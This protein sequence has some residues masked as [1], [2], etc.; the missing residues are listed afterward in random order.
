MAQC[1]AARRV[2]QLREGILRNRR[3]EQVGERT[4]DD[5]A[6]SRGHSANFAGVPFIHTPEIAALLERC[7]YVF[8]IRHPASGYVQGMND[9]VTPFIFVY[10]TEF[11]TDMNATD[12]AALSDGDLYEL[13]AD[14]YWSLNE[15]LNGIQDHY[16]FAQ[17]GIQR[18]I[19]KLHE[20]VERHRLFTDQTSRRA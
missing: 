13:E 9:L 10:L 14:C 20:L 11:D 4:N 16:T 18:Q 15:L 19:Y 8:A 6:D 12:C 7:L 17:P 3:R 2:R 1:E 5:S